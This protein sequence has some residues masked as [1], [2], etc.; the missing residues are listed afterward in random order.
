MTV[1]TRIWAV[2]SGEYSDYGVNAVFIREEDARAAVQ[3]GYGC[4]VE[5]FDLYTHGKVPA[6][7]ERAT[8]RAALDPAT[9]EQVDDRFIG[10]VEAQAKP[11]VSQEWHHPSKRPKC[12]TSVQLQHPGLEGHLVVRVAGTNNART[13]KVFHDL[14]AKTRAECVEGLHATSAQVRP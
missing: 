1:P 2:S 11:D 8:Y 14:L 4:D 7:T 6:K 5:E 3:A 12:E 13:R 9:G 10:T